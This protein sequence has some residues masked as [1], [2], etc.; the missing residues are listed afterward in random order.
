MKQ[1][2]YTHVECPKN[3][4]NTIP[5]STT[6]SHLSKRNIT[7]LNIMN[8]NLCTVNQICGFGLKEGE[9]P[10][11]W[12]RFLLPIFLHAG[13]VHIVINLSFQV[14]TGIQMERDFGT[15]RIFIIYMASGIFGFAFGANY[16]GRTTSVGCSGSLYGKLY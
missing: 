7:E 1:T 14:R 6:D 11:Q 4:K 10:N 2:N 16:S 9:V 15:W 13:V 8:P 12:F 3:I 5:L